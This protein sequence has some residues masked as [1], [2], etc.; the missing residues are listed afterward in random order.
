MRHVAQVR[1]ERPASQN[2]DDVA[3]V[4][5][6]KQ[7]GLQPLAFAVV[8]LDVGAG[9]VITANGAIIAA[10]LDLNTVLEAAMEPAVD[11]HQGRRVGPED[12]PDALAAR[13]D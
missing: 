4:S 5:R 1:T 8:K 12:L 3:I 13:R 11:G 9:N 10:V 6:V 7:F 2:V